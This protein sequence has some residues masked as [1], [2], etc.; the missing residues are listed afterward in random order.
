MLE[1]GHQ[2]WA[3]SKILNWTKNGKV[4]SWNQTEGWILSAGRG[5]IVTKD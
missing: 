5:H 4:H 3:W 2:S 1:K